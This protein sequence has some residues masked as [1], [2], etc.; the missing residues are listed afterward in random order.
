MARK[1]EMRI[2]SSAGSCH[3]SKLGPK[4]PVN[5]KNKDAF[6]DMRSRDER[7]R[8][9]LLIFAARTHADPTRMQCTLRRPRDDM[10]ACVWG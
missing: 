7:T 1:A 10:R 8:R 5:L 6:W 4:G 2:G 3:W 9:S